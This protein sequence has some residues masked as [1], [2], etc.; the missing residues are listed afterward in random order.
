MQ[1][2][3]ADG[4]LM[5]KEILGKEDVIKYFDLSQRTSSFDEE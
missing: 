4:E 1:V 2:G 3:G 5:V